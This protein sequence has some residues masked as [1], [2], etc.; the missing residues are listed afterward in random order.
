MTK[1]VDGESTTLPVEQLAPGIYFLQLAC[2]GMVT[3][4]PFIVAGN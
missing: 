2:E 1:S 4:E 3:T